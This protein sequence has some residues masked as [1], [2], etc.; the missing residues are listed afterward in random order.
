MSL[1]L[2]TKAQNLYNLKNIITTARIAPICIIKV[3]NWQS[4]S[5]ECLTKVNDVLKGIFKKIVRSSSSKEDTLKTSNAGAFLSITNVE[6]EDLRHAIN[7]VIKSYGD[8]NPNDEVLIQPMLS[9]VIRS[10]VAFT[11]D[12][13]TCSPYRIINWSESSNTTEVLV[14]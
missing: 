2:S 3:K 6:T 4:N 5:K 1:K 8:V 10:G 7:R 12:P 13:N 9:N 11:H 14:D